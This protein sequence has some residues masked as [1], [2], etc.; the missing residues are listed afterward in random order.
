MGIHILLL[1]KIY[2]VRYLILVLEDGL[3]SFPPAGR[4]NSPSCVCLSV[5]AWRLAPGGARPLSITLLP[6][7]FQGPWPLP[8]PSALLRVPL[9]FGHISANSNHQ[10]GLQHKC[11]L[12]SLCDPL[13]T[14]N[15]QCHIQGY[16][17]HKVTYQHVRA[18]SSTYQHPQV[19]LKGLGHVVRFEPR[20]TAANIIGGLGEKVAGEKDPSRYPVRR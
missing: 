14:V 6:F 10:S 20:R 18:S 19:D 16:T 1:D 17:F 2:L 13:H 9:P 12:Q 8:S 15:T 7:F 11:T 4:W 3:S 5:I